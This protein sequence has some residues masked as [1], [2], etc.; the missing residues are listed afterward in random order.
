MSENERNPIH[1]MG[2]N[3]IGCG[4]A[5][6]GID[7]TICPECGREFDPDDARTFTRVVERPAR[8]YEGPLP[9]AERIR[10]EIEMAGIPARLE[11]RSTGV[12]GYA[13]VRTATVWVSEDAIDDAHRAVAAANE[14]DSQRRAAGP[15]TCSS[16][17]EA[18]DGDFDICWNC[19]SP[20]PE[21]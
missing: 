2:I 20:R 15:W 5:L 7:S 8:V 21:D 17:G 16:C 4:Y 3:C 18:V 10:L 19:E 14:K 1:G 9:E 13:E 11:E 6:T 12:I